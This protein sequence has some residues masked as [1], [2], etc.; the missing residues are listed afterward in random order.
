MQITF[1]SFW[2]PYPADNGAKMRVLALLRALA[3]E[4]QVDLIVLSAEGVDAK[5]PGTPTELCHSVTTLAVPSFS[6]QRGLRWR[7]YIHRTPRSLLATYDASVTRLIERRFAEGECDIMICGDLAAYYGLMAARSL[8]VFIDELDPSR[9]V[10]GLRHAATMRR[11]LRAALTW[12]KHRLFARQ[13]LG[14]CAGCFVA[15]EREAALLRM[16]APYPERILIVPNGVSLAQQSNQPARVADRLVYSGSPTYAPNLD[17]VSFFA[18]D[19]LPHIRSCIPDAWLAVT[20]K[21]EG[22]PLDHLTSNPGVTFTGWLPDIRAFVA[23]SRVCVVPLREGG[24]TRLKILE[25]MA[26]GTPV[27]ATTKGAEGLDV[28]DGEDILI[29]DDPR[30]F[31]DA[32]VRLLRDDALHDRIASRARAT[33]AARY[34]W[35]TIGA[36]MLMALTRLAG[37]SSM[38]PDVDRSTRMR[39]LA[40]SPA[41]DRSA[42]SRPVVSD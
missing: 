10:D 40:R 37:P 4:H 24:G 19:I 29:A 20:G 36:D 31:A 21:T 5:D 1:L 11:R 15:S 35:E 39:A 14:V 42:R 17:A 33:V 34:D 28:T 22:A 6:S 41:R 8:P 13:L 26:L 27:V 23:A 16:I 18:A 7:D 9:F 32:T 2:H 30:A 25:A 3:R 12:W 38:H